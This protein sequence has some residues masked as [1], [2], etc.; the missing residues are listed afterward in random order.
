M[1]G[2]TALV[3]D[4]NE[5]YRTVLQDLLEEEGYDVRTAVDGMCALREAAASPPDLVILDLVM[6]KLDGA[7][8][9]RRMKADPRLERASIL[10]LSGILI[11]DIGNL[12]GIGA[13]A[14]VAK[15]PMDRLLPTLRT[16]I[17]RLEEG[18][19]ETLIDGFEGLYRREVVVELLEEKRFRDLLFAS[20]GEGAVQL[21]T[22]LR[23]V[24]VNPA[25][26]SITGRQELEILDRP[27]AEVLSLDAAVSGDLFPPSPAAASGA[28]TVELGER[29]VR[30][31]ASPIRR[32]AETLGYML[33]VEEATAIVQAEREKELLR[34]QLTQTEKLGALG[35]MVAG[36]AHE[37]N[38]PLTGILG[39]TEICMQRCDGDERLCRDLR[40]V[41]EQARRCQEI[42]GHLLTFSRRAV[43]AREPEDLNAVI[44]AVLETRREEIQDRGIDL[45]LDLQ[46][47]LPAVSL[48]RAQWGQVVIQLVRNA[49][50]AI[51][52]SRRRG[53][54][55]IASRLEHDR[56]VLEVQDNGAGIQYDVLPRIFDPF[57][58]T[59]DVGDGSGLGLSVAYGIVR[60]H[61]GRIL[62]DGRPGQGARFTVEIPLPREDAVLTA[63]LPATERGTEPPRVLVVDDEPVIRDL[64]VDL[65][66]AKGVR[67]ETSDNGREALEKLENGGFDV[68][69]LD[70]KMP[71]MGGREVYERLREA[72]PDLLQRVV[73]S[74]G[75][76]VSEESRD[77]FRSISA[78]VIQKPFQIDQVTRTLQSFLGRGTEHAAGC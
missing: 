31:K 67:V 16:M 22:D 27:V 55:R 17:R 32:E 21:D 19:E 57:F 14:Y 46:A 64:L 11:E 4:N 59:G 38:N 10:I 13:D 52:R 65:L 58:T 61:Q 15:M 43:P 47:D 51:G 56:V 40:R 54:L 33:L 74:T 6:P 48:D 60:Q 68:V 2:K 12:D 41:H 28:R 73:F 35:Q 9:C 75:D 78:P 37:L 24:A 53:T 69:V 25:F 44:R 71:E 30:L 76:M 8:V 34:Q 3:V 63:D 39:Y 29:T 23:V 45:Q 1:M 18:S 42:V 66:E 7:R 50:Q 62:V 77:F 5:F 26:L 20:L 36:A 49:C 72:R 70:L